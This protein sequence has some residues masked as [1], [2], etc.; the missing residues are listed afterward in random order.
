VRRALAGDPL[1]ERLGPLLLLAP[2]EN[3]IAN[4]MVDIDLKFVLKQNL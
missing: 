1:L 4:D 2:S 3:W